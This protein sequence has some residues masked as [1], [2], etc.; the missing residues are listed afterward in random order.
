[1]DTD[2][3]RSWLGVAEEHFDYWMPTVWKI[4]GVYGIVDAIWL[5][6]TVPADPL[7]PRAVRL[8]LAV[9]VLVASYHGRLWRDRY[10]EDR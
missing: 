6:W 4:L 1:M 2:N 7:D 9:F 5:Q 3:L 10:F 8:I